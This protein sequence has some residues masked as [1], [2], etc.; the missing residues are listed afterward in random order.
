MNLEVLNFENP[1]TKFEKE[2]QTSGLHDDKKVVLFPLCVIKF[3]TVFFF[4]SKM[5]LCVLN[6]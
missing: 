6:A 5:F 1:L 3:A 2:W 4:F